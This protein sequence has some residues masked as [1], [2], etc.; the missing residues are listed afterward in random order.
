[1]ASS[2]YNYYSI[3]KKCTGGYKQGKH[4]DELGGH[5]VVQAGDDNVVRKWVQTRELQGK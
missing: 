2:D 3:E 4:R 1:M 5:Q